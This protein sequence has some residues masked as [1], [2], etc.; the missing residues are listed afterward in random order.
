[1]LSSAVALRWERP[2]AVEVIHLALTGN[3][4]GSGILRSETPVHPG[5]DTGAPAL[6]KSL[7]SSHA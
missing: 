7:V 5:V 2:Q 6:D 1:M 4:T 3:H